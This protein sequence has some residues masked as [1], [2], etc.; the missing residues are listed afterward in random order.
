MRFN[1]NDKHTH[2]GH[3]RSPVVD[4]AACLKIAVQQQQCRVAI[5]INHRRRR[6]RLTGHRVHT[7]AVHI[8]KI[9]SSA[10]RMKKIGARSPLRIVLVK[11]YGH[12]PTPDLNC[13]ACAYN[14]AATQTC[15]RLMVITA[16]TAWPGHPHHGERRT[17]GGG[18]AETQHLQWEMCGHC[19]HSTQ[20]MQSSVVKEVT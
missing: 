14:T 20:F 3:S 6:G 12:T 13:T 17:H 11:K 5:T 1:A 18:S 2:A 10:E 8:L 9:G 4:L 16:I 19:K 15:T 7:I